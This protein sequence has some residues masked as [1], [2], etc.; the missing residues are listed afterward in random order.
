MTATSA[1]ASE[2]RDIKLRPT[3]REISVRLELVAAASAI[4]GGW[5]RNLTPLFCQPG[6]PAMSKRHGDSPTIRAVIMWCYKAT[7][8]LTLILQ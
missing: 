2:P 3:A 6:R 7:T 5:L 8:D 1:A 4:V